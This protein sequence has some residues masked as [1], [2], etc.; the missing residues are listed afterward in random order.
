MPVK[1]NKS[2]KTKQMKADILVVGSTGLVG[3]A[4][5]KLIRNDPSAGKILVLARRKIPAIADAPHVQKEIVDFNNLD[6]Y[7]HL[8]SARTMVCALGTTIKKASSKEGF[9]QVDYQIPMNIARYAVKNGCE[10]F[11]LISAIGAN[12][13]SSVFYNKVKGELERDIQTLSFKSIHIIRPS[14]LM[15]DREE[16]RFGEEIGKLLIQPFSFLI[17][18]KYKP[19][20]VDVIARKIRSL[21]KDNTPGVHIYEGRQIYEL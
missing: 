15:G 4:F 18:D 1:K 2:S 7:K 8:L 13:D 6:K 10:I 12:P 9:R 17:P 5:L 21:L 11:I 3:G 20:H 14:L 16:F 19:V